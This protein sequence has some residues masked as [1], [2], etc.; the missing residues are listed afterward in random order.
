MTTTVCEQLIYQNAIGDGCANS[1]AWKS[2]DDK[3]D[4]CMAKNR[5]EHTG[6][7]SSPQELERI[8]HIEDICAVFPNKS[9][10]IYQNEPH[11]VI[12]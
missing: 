5:Y 11:S 3:L 8:S 2:H 6:G 7:I 4:N 12:K 1:F 9:R 10:N